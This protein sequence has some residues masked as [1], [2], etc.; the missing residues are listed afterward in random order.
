MVFSGEIKSKSLEEISIIL[1]VK[2]IGKFNV[3]AVY[4]VDSLYLSITDVF[5]LLRIDQN[6]SVFNDTIAGFFVSEKFHYSINY[7][8]Q[9]IRI[10]DQIFKATKLDLIKTESGLYISQNMLGKAFGLY[11]T[12]DKELMMVE[13]QTET[14]LPAIKEMKQLAIRNNINRLAGKISADTLSER[15]CHLFNGGMADWMVSSTRSS[16]SKSQNQA[17]IGLGA[18]V[19]Y[20]ETNIYLNYNSSSE[21][22]LKKQVCLWRWVDNSQTVFR[23]IQV[24]SISNNAITTIREPVLGMMITN[25]PT[26][27]RSTYGTFTYSDFIEPNWTVELYVNN[28]LVDYAS[29]DASGYYKFDVPLVY[30]YSDVKLKFFGPYGEEQIKEQ[31]INIPFNFIPKGELE[32][33]LQSGEVMDQAHS[34]FSRGKANYGISKSITVGGG[35]EYLSSLQNTK[36]IPFINSSASL[37][38]GVLLNAEYFHQVRAKADVSYMSKA[39]LAIH[40]EFQ[41]YNPNQTVI[42][43]DAGDEVKFSINS[44]YKVFNNTGS[45]SLAYSKKQYAPSVWQNTS[46][47]TTSTRIGRFS[48]NINTIIKWQEKQ[49]GSFI[50]NLGLNYRLDR[51]YNF[52]TMAMFDL[53]KQELTNIVSS[54][55]RRINDE[56]NISLSLDNNFTSNQP[57]VSFSLQY[58][59]PFAQTRLSSN[60]RKNNI[61]TGQGANGS[62]VYD[63]KNKYIHATTQN[64]VGMGAITIIPFLD[65]NQNG[66]RDSNEHLV[67]DVE[68]Q[69][70]GG[71]IMESRNDTLIRITGLELYTGHL[72]EFRE[73][74][75]KNISWQIKQKV[76]KVFPDPNQVKQIFLPILPM[77]E[78]FGVVYIKKNNVEVGQ[79]QISVS[80]Y[81][82]DGTKVANTMSE[83]DGYFSH[84]G[85]APGNYYAKLD[86]L[87]MQRLNMTAEADSIPFTIRPSEDGDLVNNL[88][89]KLLPSESLTFKPNITN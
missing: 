38:N 2:G 81:K 6:V 32:Y 34:L 25:T 27:Y 63:P 70:Q 40:L 7:S 20:G 87:Q 33:S 68:V 12:F 62:F 76:I 54:I 9:K 51:R 1:N 65:I 43:Y 19:L 82:S 29:T 13:M 88:V 69:S 37:L 14:E 10:G 72:I 80:F 44:P 55:E 83:S 23:Q 11:C 78:A 74:K 84:L 3:N 75:L 57:G 60:I 61:E 5:Q 56:F 41:K 79:G 16:L 47:L 26:T 86:K 35:A 48:S 71:R 77:G 30:G 67:A 17:K 4:A 73:S 59:L 52:H 85:F 66:I 42:S 50:S 36:I 49:I 58:N 28:S 22:D 64:T 53:S 45:I 21:F 8:D 31:H 46:Q 39:N 15:R 89:L 24:G 18:E